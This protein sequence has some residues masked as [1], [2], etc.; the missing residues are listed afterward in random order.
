M[1]IAILIS[2]NECVKKNASKIA[3][4]IGCSVIF[5]ATPFEVELGDQRH[6]LVN[7]MK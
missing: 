4:I 6:L 5:I 3:E 2:F 1:N 7:Y